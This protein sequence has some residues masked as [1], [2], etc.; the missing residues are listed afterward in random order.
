LA[1]KVAAGSLKAIVKYNCLQCV[2][3]QPKEVRLC[4]IKS[5]QS[6]SARPYK[7]ES[8]KAR[9]P[10]STVVDTEQSSDILGLPDMGIED[11]TNQFE[12]IYS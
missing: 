5:C 3:F 1:E 12:A 4:G 11:S 6:Y 9:I 10:L 8:E 7:T 2:G